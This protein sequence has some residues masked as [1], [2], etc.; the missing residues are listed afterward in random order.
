VRTAA[1]L[2]LGSARD[3][4]GEEEMLFLLHDPDARVQ[5]LCEAALQSRGLNDGQILL[6]RLI[7]DPRPEERLRIVLQL[8]QVDGVEPGIWLNK[9]SQDPADAVRAA[10]VRL[11]A[12]LPGVNFTGRLA[13]MADNDP[14]ETVR[15]LARFYLLR[16][17]L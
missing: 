1:L 14:S 3:I 6:G 2:A 10:A 16:R 7:S 15:Q 8:P 4:L 9:L 17:S 12:S 13:Q 11:A 5:R